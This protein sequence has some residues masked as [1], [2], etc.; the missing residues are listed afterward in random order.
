MRPVLL[1][2]LV[3]CIAPAAQPEAPKGP[4]PC[5]RVGDHLVG[6]MTAGI[7]DKERPT[8]TID[9]LT[10]VIISLCSDGKWSADAQQCFLGINSLAGQAEAWDRCA[11]MLTI[12]Q[13]EEL[14]R[15]ID[16]AFGP[17]KPG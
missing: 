16:A 11:S 6:L 2:A 10:K 5:E 4:R 12:E 1:L 8:D 14:P 9:K 15:A 17:R 7:P 3:A 13:R